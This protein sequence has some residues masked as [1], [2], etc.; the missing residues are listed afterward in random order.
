MT[1]H[2]ISPEHSQVKGW[3]SFD[4]KCMQNSLHLHSF[5]SSALSLAIPAICQ[6][7]QNKEIIHS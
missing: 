5:Q 4:L 1:H 2:C 6:Q 3:L 7:I